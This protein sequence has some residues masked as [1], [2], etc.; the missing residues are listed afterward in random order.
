MKQS[1]N[2]H[3]F[4]QSIIT[5]LHFPEDSD[6]HQGL[7]SE[8]VLPYSFFFL[9]ELHLP[10]VFWN[11]EYKNTSSFSYLFKNPIISF[12]NEIW[13]GFL[14]IS[15]VV[16]YIFATTWSH[17][18]RVIKIKGLPWWLSSQESTWK[19]RRLGFNPWVGKIAWRRKW[20]PTPVFLSGKSYGQRS[21]A[22]HSPWGH[23]VLDTT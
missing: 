22:G 6:G 18:I 11:T 12:W 2:L 3:F 7:N 13:I 16:K 20:Q 15:S 8:Y 10:Y 23:Q 5:R 19:Y 4:R 21:L 9:H 17:K 1:M 14:F